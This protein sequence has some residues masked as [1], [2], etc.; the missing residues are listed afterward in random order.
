MGSF[1]EEILDKEGRVEISS[2]IWIFLTKQE[3][4]E[5]KVQA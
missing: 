4:M 2:R 3:S 5:K 1:S